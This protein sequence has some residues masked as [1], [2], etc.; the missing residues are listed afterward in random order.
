MSIR[1]AAFLRH[2][3]EHFAFG[4][5]PRDWNEHMTLADRSMPDNAGVDREWWRRTDELRREAAKVRRASADLITYS[6]EIRER[7]AT[8]KRRIAELLD[9]GSFSD[10]HPHT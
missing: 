1:P 9:R 3:S 4:Y 7:I 5:E 10:P 6:R 2:G 8:I